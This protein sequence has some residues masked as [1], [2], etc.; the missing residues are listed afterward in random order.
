M[1]KPKPKRGR[2]HIYGSDHERKERQ[3]QFQREYEERKERRGLKRLS[4]IW[5]PTNILNG[6]KQES[7]KSGLSLQDIIASKLKM[8]QK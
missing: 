3:Q 2:P 5:L 7:E 6:L 8:S 1:D 4:G